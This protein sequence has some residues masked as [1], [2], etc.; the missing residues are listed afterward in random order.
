MLPFLDLCQHS[1]TGLIRILS[2]S[3]KRLSL[4]PGSEVGGPGLGVR[5][6]GLGIR[7]GGLEVEAQRSPRLLVGDN[8][9]QTTRCTFVLLEYSS[10]VHVDQ[11]DALLNYMWERRRWLHVTL[12]SP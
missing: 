7:A 1:I 10:L 12:N 3:N 5:V 11:G 6:R 9:K 4:S 2:L 8:S